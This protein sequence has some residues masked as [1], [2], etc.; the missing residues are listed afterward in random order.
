MTCFTGSNGNCCL[1]WAGNKN[2]LS[3]N[4][5][6]GDLKWKLTLQEKSIKYWRGLCCHIVFQVFESEETLSAEAPQLWQFNQNSTE[7]MWF[8]LCFVV[9]RAVVSQ[10]IDDLKLKVF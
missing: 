1:P 7:E 8:L 6:A 3:N 2:T 5:Y 4:T 10:S 9:V